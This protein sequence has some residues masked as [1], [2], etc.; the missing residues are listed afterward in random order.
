[1]MGTSKIMGVPMK[2]PNTSDKTVVGSR[3]AADRSMDEEDTDDTAV[4]KESKLSIAEIPA[5]VEAGS[6]F[7]ADDDEIRAV[8]GI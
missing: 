1:M 2:T 7:C 6:M 3:V 5:F 4:A 8:I